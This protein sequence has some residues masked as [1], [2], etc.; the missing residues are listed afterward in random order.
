[1]EAGGKATEVMEAVG[2]QPTR[3]E[4]DP[5]HRVKGATR[6]GVS[7]AGDVQGVLGPEDKE[8]GGEVRNGE[9][10]WTLGGEARL[11]VKDR[12]VSGEG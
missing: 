12:A 9:K 6:A 1:M 5:C 2:K 8:E 11:G 4:G 3:E 10:R 7:L